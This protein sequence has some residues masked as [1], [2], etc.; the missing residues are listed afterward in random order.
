MERDRL[1]DT[2][3]YV[4]VKPCGCVVAWVSGST[5]ADYI[6]STV[7]RWIKGG[8]SVE[9]KTTREAREV[10]RRCRCGVD[11]VP[12]AGQGAIDYTGEVSG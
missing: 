10:L 3:D 7:A 5:S 9:R 11:P 1:S 6:A 8:Y 2:V 12:C 4:A